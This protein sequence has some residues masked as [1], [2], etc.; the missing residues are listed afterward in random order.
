MFCSSVDWVRTSTLLS[1]QFECKALLAISSEAYLQATSSTASLVAQMVVNLPAM[2]ET[3]VLSWGQEDRLEKE[4][5]TH[6]SILAWRIP[7]GR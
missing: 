6:S 1:H 4:V 7:M 5:T 2:Q 3:H